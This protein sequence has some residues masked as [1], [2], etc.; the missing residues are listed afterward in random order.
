MYHQV[1]H[2]QSTDE[3]RFCTTPADFAAQMELL[4]SEGYRAVDIEAVVDHVAGAVRLPEKAVH[5]TFDDGFVGVLEHALPTLK[6]LGIPAT[7]YAL[8]RRTGRSN[9]WMHGRGLPRRQLLSSR[10][11]YTIAEEGFT[12]GSHSCTHARLPEIPPHAAREE[13][14]ASREELEAMLGREV[15]HFAYPYGAFN[16]AVRQ[17]VIEAGYRSACTTHSGFNRAGEDPFRLRRIDIAGNDRL[18]QFRQK[19]A[20]GTNTASR[21]QPL[22]Y[23]ARRIGARLGFVR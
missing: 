14:A 17:M 22:A 11:L 4:A 18:W 13:I 10:Q 8:P 3:R 15:R 21:L 9:D 12:I 7:L 2:P 1:E 16:D 19:L 23:A 20:F 6:R 5:V